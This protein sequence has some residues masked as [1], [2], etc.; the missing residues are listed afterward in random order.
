MPVVNQVIIFFFFLCQERLLTLYEQTYN[1]D[2][3]K[4]TLGIPMFG[5]T[6]DVRGAC[7]SFY[8]ADETFDLDRIPLHKPCIKGKPGIYSDTPGILYSYEVQYYYLHECYCTLN[9]C[10]F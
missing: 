4:A 1:I 5:T 9:G 3:S 10:I 2:L 8:G 7:S 6:Y